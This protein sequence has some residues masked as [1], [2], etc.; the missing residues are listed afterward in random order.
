M[1]NEKIPFDQAFGDSGGRALNRN[2]ARIREE[3]EP[4]M[5]W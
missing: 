2:S 3:Q 4:A 1:N 5:T